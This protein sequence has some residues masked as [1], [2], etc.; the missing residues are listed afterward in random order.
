MALDTMTLVPSILAMLWHCAPLTCIWE[1]GRGSH[2]TLAILFIAEI[3]VKDV[4]LHG[5][6][7]ETFLSGLSI[8][9]SCA[10]QKGG[11]CF[12]CRHSEHCN[13]LCF[14]SF[15]SQK[16]QSQIWNPLQGMYLKYLGCSSCLWLYFLFL[17]FPSVMLQHWIYGFR[18]NFK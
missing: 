9:K 17:I 16:A 7:Q 8:R 3:I 5:R 4:D 1:V 15:G 13:Q 14:L 10:S 2:S 11:G 18:Y 12:H 6:S